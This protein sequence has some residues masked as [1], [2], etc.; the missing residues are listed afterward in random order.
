MFDLNNNNNNFSSYTLNETKEFVPKH[1]LELCIPP[2][3]INKT[4]LNLS[5]L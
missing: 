2:T 1:G 4:F 3:R 5:S